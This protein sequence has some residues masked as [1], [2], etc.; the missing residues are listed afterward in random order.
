MGRRRA[1]RGG[2]GKKA[3]LKHAKAFYDPYSPYAIRSRGIKSID[4]HTPTPVSAADKMWRKTM[5]QDGKATLT[6]TTT[7]PLPRHAALKAAALAKKRATDRPADKT[8]LVLL[9][10]WQGMRQQGLTEWNRIVLIQRPDLELDLFF[11]GS[12]FIFIK[13]SKKIQARSKEYDG[14][15]NAF[16]ALRLDNIF[17]TEVIPLSTPPP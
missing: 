2:S 7:M 16:K 15:A 4:L 12:K 17:W 14:R 8:A 11:S 13:Q 6:V 10:Q 3:Y 1:R 9:E 5:G